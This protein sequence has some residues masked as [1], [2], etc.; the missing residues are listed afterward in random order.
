MLRP[1]AALHLLLLTAIALPH[2]LRA[3]A[4]CRTSCGSI[5]ITYPFAIDDGCGSPLFRGLLSCNASTGT[6]SFIALSGA[7]HVQS[8]DYDAHTI[9]LYDPAMSTCSILQ[10]RHDSFLLSDV[11]HALL[12]PTP[13]TVFALM[14][15]SVDSPILHRFSYLCFPNLYSHTCQDIYHSCPSFKFFTTGTAPAATTT[16]NG[17]FLSGGGSLTLSN[18]SSGYNNNG[19][20]FGTGPP[21]CFTGYDTVKFMSMDML[22]CT[23]YIS[24]V[25]GGRGGYG[26]FGSSG[27]MDWLYGIKL[28]YGLPESGCDRCKRSGG[29]CG[30]DTETE[31]S[32]CLCSVVM[33]ATRECGP[34]ADRGEHITVKMFYLYTLFVIVIAS[35]GL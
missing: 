26:E 23:H 16:N 14:N 31:T 13:D 2:V 1:S 12:P 29:V 34:V 3:Y 7:Y 9:L 5:S 35:V 21:C 32:L 24:F 15:C 4:P 25:M 10:P 33:N 22:D 8:I 11:S 30:F 17:T 6:L 28:S 18:T 19:N 20:I 27:P